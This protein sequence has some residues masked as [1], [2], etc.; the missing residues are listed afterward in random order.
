MAYQLLKN[1][2]ERLITWLIR[3]YGGADTI[4][5]ILDTSFGVS[6]MYLGT[7]LRGRPA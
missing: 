5:G 2:S 3:F 7:G 6:C 4:Y 1:L